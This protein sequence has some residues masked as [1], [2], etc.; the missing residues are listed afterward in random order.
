MQAIK[1]N[2]IGYLLDT[3]I[4]GC[5]QNYLAILTCSSRK[6]ILVVSY[7]NNPIFAHFGPGGLEKGTETVID[8]NWWF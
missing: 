3:T 6:D 5:S 4:R 7:S 2:Q 1:M 8:Q